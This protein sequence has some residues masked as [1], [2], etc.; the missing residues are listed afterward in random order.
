MYKV[1]DEIKIP[2]NDICDTILANGEKLVLIKDDVK[3]IYEKDRWYISNKLVDKL[4][5]GY[6]Y[7]PDFTLQNKIDNEMFD[8]VFEYMEVTDESIE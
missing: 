8:D 6:G 5:M 4:F 3:Y 7:M 2:S 1:K